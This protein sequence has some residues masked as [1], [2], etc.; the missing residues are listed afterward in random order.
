VIDP[1]GAK[2]LAA[3]LTGMADPTRLLALYR[4]VGGPASVGR[5]AELTRVPLVNLSHHLGVMWGARL[6]DR[7][8]QGRRVIYSLRPGLFTPAGGPGEL[9]TLTLGAYRLTLLD[10][11]AVKSA[12][13]WRK[14]V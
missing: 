9:G 3:L 4:L 14:K 6:L 8:K 10:R 13:K 12:P 1:S 5:L 2:A 7:E 11:P